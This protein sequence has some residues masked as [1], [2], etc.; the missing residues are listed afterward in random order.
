[1]DEAYDGLGATFDLYAEVYGRNSIDD[2]GMDMV[3]TV[4]F[5]RNFGNALWDGKQMIFGDGD[6]EVF[7]R[8]TVA[9]DVMGHELTHGVIQYDVPPNG[10]EYSNQPGALNESIA[11]VFGSLVKQYSLGQTADEADWLI[12]EGLII[13]AE[14]LRSL[15]E[16]SAGLDPQ[17]AHMRDYVNTAKDNGGVHTNSG[18]PNHAFYLAATEIGGYAWEGAGLIWYLTLPLVSAKAQFQDFASQTL[19]TAQRLFGVNSPEDEAVGN[20]WAQVGINL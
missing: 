8:M 16:P 2:N 1:V 3:G 13:G 17:P 11:D 14:A 20:A 4:H 9:I 7:N 5:G 18:I 12:G 15:Q 19:A 6:G 10:L